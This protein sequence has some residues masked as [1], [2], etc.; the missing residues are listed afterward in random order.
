[1]QMTPEPEAP[2]AT[3]VADGGP[4]EPQVSSSPA[5]QTPPVETAGAQ[6]PRALRSLIAFWMKINND[7][8]FNLAGLLAYNLLLSTFPILVLLLASAGFALGSVSPSAQDIVQR[9]V[10]NVLPDTAGPA[11]VQSVADHLRASARWLLVVGLVTS[12]ITGSRLF[13]TIESCF[14]IIFRLRGRNPITQN[15]MALGMLALYIVLVPLLVFASIVPGAIVQAI[16]P[17]GHSGLERDA[18]TVT[19]IIIAYVASFLLFT[20]TYLIVP[21]RTKH[22]WQIWPG[23]LAAS[24]LLVIYELVFPLYEHDLLHPDNYG[25]VAGFAVV[26]LLFFYYLAF[27]LLLGAELNSWIIGQRETAADLPGILHEIQAHRSLR[28]AAGP[29]AGQPQEELQQ[30]RRW[31]WRRR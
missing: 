18:I 30:H 9:G 26:I 14:R 5:L 28:G 29:T 19:G 24:T 11:L 23:V 16:N 25:S 17:S 21:N 7:W 8:I 31:P 13:I 12:V 20:L 22:R 2:H 4:S 6:H 1:M 10:A 27:I 3:G 15:L